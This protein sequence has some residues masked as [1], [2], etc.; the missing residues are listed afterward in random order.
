MGISDPEHEV[1]LLMMNENELMRVTETDLESES[2]D[3]NVEAFSSRRPP[4]KGSKPY[5]NQPTGTKNKPQKF[6]VPESMK[7]R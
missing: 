7:N 1:D 3:I 2:G 6:R 5:S 4:Q